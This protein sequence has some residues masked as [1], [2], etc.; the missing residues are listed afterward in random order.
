MNVRPPSIL[1]SLVM[2]LRA[3]VSLAAEGFPSHD[4]RI[5]VSVGTDAIARVREGYRLDGPVEGATFEYLQDSCSSVSPISASSGNRS[6]G[7]EV[8]HRGPW[9]FLHAGAGPGQGANQLDLSYT[10]RL[11][12]GA[13]IPI[14]M[15]AA[16]LARAGESR[17]AD[18][19][20]AVTFAGGTSAGTVVLP[21]LARADNT[22]SWRAQF[23][24]IPSVIRLG[25]SHDAES[26]C[27]RR[28]SGT[29][30]GLEWRFR[31]FVLTMAVWIP[32]YFFW[33][34]RRGDRA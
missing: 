1:F 6:L 29:T 31:I 22:G 9:T 4:V 23:S 32:V 15:P 17:G 27:V 26:S 24:A 30:G 18:V 20:V 11:N 25:A 13:S 14:V 3:A 16:T 7:F 5:D 2:F 8:G 19:E 12:G 33:F 28:S 34:G 10:V 21:R